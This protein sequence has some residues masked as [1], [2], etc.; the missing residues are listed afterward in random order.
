MIRQV[1]QSF[2]LR[3]TLPSDNHALSNVLGV[4]VLTGDFGKSPTRQALT[5][6]IQTI[7]LLPK[8]EG[9]SRARI[10]PKAISDAGAVLHT[11]LPKGARTT[12]RFLLVDDD[13]E[14]HNWA[15]F[16]AKCLGLRQS[17]L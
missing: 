7:D 9:R 3:L 8:A 1:W 12:L 14:R 6:L 10:C 5:K 11:G 15:V 2:F 17:S 13:Q 4:G 16:A